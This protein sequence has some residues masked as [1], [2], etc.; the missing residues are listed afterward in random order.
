MRTTC[1]TGAKD[2]LY[3]SLV[4]NR[5]ACHRCAELTNPADVQG[6]TLDSDHVG[7]WSLWQGNLDADLMVVGQDWGDTRYFVEGGGREGPRNRTNLTLAELAGVV[8]V[9]ISEP[10]S[11]EGEGI[12]FFTNAVLCLKEGGLQAPVRR[13]WFDNC[14]PFL[15]RQIEIIKPKVVVGLGEKA[16]QTIAKAFGIRVGRFRSEVEMEGGRLL[17]TGARAFAV[18]H[19]G[20]R[21][22]NTHRKLEEQKKDW[23]RI[24]AFLRAGSSFRGSA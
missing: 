15:R 22:Q 2:T 6:G 3:A 11:S 12:A 4:A 5:K 17:P 20:A 21:I 16:Y 7:P 9:T 13:T 23:R 24:R 8:G 18:Y 1:A 14:A 10:G 19:C